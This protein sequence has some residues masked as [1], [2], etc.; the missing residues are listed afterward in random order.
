MWSRLRWIRTITCPDCKGTG[1][2]S[3]LPTEWERWTRAHATAVAEHERLLVAYQA[4]EA[5][6]AELGAAVDALT[7]QVMSAPDG[8][9]CETCGGYGRKP[10][11]RKRI[12][13][14]RRL[15]L[16]LGRAAA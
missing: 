13:R 6:R 3:G 7:D 8:H 14:P 16:S 4:G 1:H 5:T 12:H 11:Q 10:L 9:D 15:H 2:I